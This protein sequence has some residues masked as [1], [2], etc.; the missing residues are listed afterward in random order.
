MNVTDTLRRT[1]KSAKV[2]RYLS[3]IFRLR[4]LYSSAKIASLMRWHHEGRTRYGMLRHLADSLAWKAFNAR[5]F[6]FASNIHNVR[7]GLASDGLNPFWTLN[8]TY[9]TW[10]VVLIPYNLLSWMC[11][12]QS[13]LILLM[14]IPS[15]KGPENDIDIFL[16]PLIDKLK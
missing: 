12:K 5:H 3:L 4:R 11:M 7:F 16:Q 13:S 8:S 15:D 9:S 1:K 6:D 10:P 14:V 2:L